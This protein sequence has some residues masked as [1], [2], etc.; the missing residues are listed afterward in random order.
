MPTF[1]WEPNFEVNIKVIDDQ[2]RKLVETVNLLY[3]SILAGES[4]QMLS[5]IFERMVEYDTFHFS[6]EEDLMI[7]FNFSGYQEHRREHEECTKNVLEFK[8][9][10]ESGEKAITIELISFLVNWV[11]HHLLH[12]DKKYAAFFKEKGLV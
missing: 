7:K 1:F 12:V 9:Q 6:T 2:H 3:D 8:H 10:F 4:P 5:E 11:H